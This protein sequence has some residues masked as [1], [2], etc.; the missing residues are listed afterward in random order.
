MSPTS[1]RDPLVCAHTS[2]RPA[3]AGKVRGITKI[4]H[5]SNFATGGHMVGHQVSTIEAGA[6]CPVHNHRGADEL[7]Q[8]LSGVGVV[9][10]NGE[11]TYLHPGDSAYVPAGADHQIGAAS[12]LDD[13]SVVSGNESFV[14]ACTLIVAPGHEDDTEPWLPTSD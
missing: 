7:F 3:E 13:P 6:I 2:D 14:V 9:V 1:T 11:T 10:I 4:T 5:S 8:V 12:A